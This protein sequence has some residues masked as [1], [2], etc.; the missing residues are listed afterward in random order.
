[1]DWGEERS[2]QW[3]VVS[4]GIGQPDR[5]DFYVL[6]VALPSAQ[7]ATLVQS[8]LIPTNSGL[9]G[10]GRGEVGRDRSKHDSTC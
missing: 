10:A 4:Y 3:K 8:H 9:R 6:L 7:P 2:D 5:T 1:M